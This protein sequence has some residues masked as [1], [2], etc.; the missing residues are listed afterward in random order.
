LSETISTLLDENRVFEP[1]AE[2]AAS[3]NANDAA[4]YDE[5]DRD[6]EAFWACWA[7]KLDWFQK[8]DKVLEWNLPYAR[9]FV[10]GRLNA[11]YNCLDRHVQAGRGSRTAIIW[12]GEP[13]DTRHVTYGELLEDVCRVAN[14]LK[15]LGVRKGDR[16]CIYL[17]MV[18]ELPVAMLALARPIPW[19][20]EGSAPSRCTTA[21]TTHRPRSW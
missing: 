14:A 12:E 16:V 17:P 7:E 3:A 9:W 19:C 13:G 1:S 11:A 21:S 2:F 6:F 20:S 15:S 8:W 18:P 10:E 5:A 4:L